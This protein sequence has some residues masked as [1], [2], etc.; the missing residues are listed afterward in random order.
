MVERPASVVKELLE[1]AVDAGAARIEVATAGGGMTLIRVTDDGVGIGRDDLRLA[2]ERHCTSK[3]SGG[4][5]AIETMGFRGEALASIAA[6]A[7][8]SVAS[9]TRENDSGWRITVEGGRATPVAPAVVNPGTQVEV[10][11]LFFAT[12]ARLKFMK[13]ERAE[14]TA[15]SEIVRQAALAHPNIRFAI[16]GSDR[17]MLSLASAGPDGLLSRVEQIFGRDFR[18][19]AI[20]IDAERDGVGLSGYVSLPTFN[21]G[22]AA[23]QYFFVNGRPVRDKQLFGALRAAYA[24]FLARDRHAV[25]VLFLRLPP[26][27]VD[28]NV[29]PAKAEVRFR[30]AGLVRGLVIGGIREALAVEG[31]RSST[32]GA[33]SM[34]AAFSRQQTPSDYPSTAPVGFSEAEQTPFRDIGGSADIRPDSLNSATPEKIEALPLGVARAQVHENYIISQTSDGMIVVDQHAAHERLVYERLKQ[35][36]GERRVETQL[37]LVP[38]VVELSEDDVGRLIARL[39]ELTALGLVIERFGHGAVAVREVPVLL[40]DANV[41][42]L[43]ND[44]VDELSDLEATTA[45]SARIEK[46]AGTIACH[47]SVRSGRRLRPEE[48]DALL[49][50]MEATPHSG[51][52]IHGRPTY[53]ELKLADLERLFGR[54]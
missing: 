13:S 8:V 2:V 27:L 40:S 49:R 20:A 16:T 23:R 7:R 37:L 14:A 42:G 5:N 53:I 4:L 21:R 6:V 38:E 54:K 28:V 30:D 48:M 34:Q 24:D 51:Q 43:V 12:P 11:D 3:L 31:H 46:V 1:N 33:I 32:T 15:I 52:C 26:A 44:I 19:N 25:A 50:Q 45:L 17:S 36:I 29:H 18:E 41:T 47:G 35:A 9:R 10:K 22:N 39:P